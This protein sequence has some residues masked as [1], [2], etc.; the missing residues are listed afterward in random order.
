VPPQQEAA[1][2]ERAKPEEENTW[3][4]ISQPSLASMVVACCRMP[5]VLAQ[6][7]QHLYGVDMLHEAQVEAHSEAVVEFLLEH[8]AKG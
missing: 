4:N 3:P 2:K 5:F 6:E 7:I 8:S 1:R